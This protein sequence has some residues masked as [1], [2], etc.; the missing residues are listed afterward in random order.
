MRRRDRRAAHLDQLRD[1]EN[2]EGG[3]GGEETGK[4]GE[5]DEVLMKNYEILNTRLPFFLVARATRR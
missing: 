5:T 4:E 2:G 3:A 1:S